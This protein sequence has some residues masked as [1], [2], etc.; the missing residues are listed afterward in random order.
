MHALGRAHGHEL[1]MGA[2]PLAIGL[3]EPVDGVVER[4]LRD[5]ALGQLD[6]LILRSACPGAHLHGDPPSTLAAACVFVFTTRSRGVV[7]LVTKCLQQHPI[8]QRHEDKPRGPALPLDGVAGVEARRPA[9]ARPARV[10]DAAGRGLR[11]RQAPGDGLRHDHRPRHHQRCPAD[12]RP[13]RRLRVRGADRVV[14]GRAA[15]RAHPLPRDHAGRSRLAAGPRRRRRGRRGLPA[16]A[17]DHLRAGASLLRRR[18]AAAPAP[19][20]PARAAV[21]HL[22]G[23]QRLPRA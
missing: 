18:G 4:L 16:R 20:A 21:R 22:G 17:R 1:V 15:G 3:H 12:R 7:R 10:R 13:A 8:L 5:H 9:R 14:Q 6:E 23:P 2:E 11:P 19:P